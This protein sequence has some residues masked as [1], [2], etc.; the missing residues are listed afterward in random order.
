MNPLRGTLYRLQS[1]ANSGEFFDQVL[2]VIN[3]D[4]L[5]RL[6]DAVEVSTTMLP[7]MLVGV[8]E[9]APAIRGKLW[10]EGNDAARI[11][12]ASEYDQCFLFDHGCCRVVI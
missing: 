7:H 11:A 4:G 6:D 5:G 3:C 12:P 9:V 8:T 2:G 1:V 10:K